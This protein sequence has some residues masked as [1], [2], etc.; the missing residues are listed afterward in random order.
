MKSKLEITTNLND[1]LFFSIPKIYMDT[2]PPYIVSLEPRVAT[3]MR[4]EEDEVR[5]DGNSS[6]EE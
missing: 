2:Q 3:N 1:K 4:V 5:L 6:T